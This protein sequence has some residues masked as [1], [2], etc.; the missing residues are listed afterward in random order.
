MAKRILNVVIGKYDIRLLSFQAFRAVNI[1]LVISISMILWQ[2][3][4]FFL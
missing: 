1:S 3:H 2:S 4:T